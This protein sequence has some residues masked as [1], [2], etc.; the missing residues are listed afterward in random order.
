MIKIH[1]TKMNKKI[2]Y[3]QF[4]YTTELKTRTIKKVKKKSHPVQ[5]K[6]YWYVISPIPSRFPGI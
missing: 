3:L 1:D 5:D 6:K 4:N 2:L